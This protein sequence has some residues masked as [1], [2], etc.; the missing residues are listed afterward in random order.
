MSRPIRP[1]LDPHAVVQK[2]K[3]T[4]SSVG[5][6]SERLRAVHVRGRRQRE[7]VA[8]PLCARRRSDEPPAGV[9][10]LR[11]LT[12]YECGNIDSEGVGGRSI[13]GMLFRPR[14]NIHR[15]IYA[16]AG[17][18]NTSLPRGDGSVVW[19]SVT[20]C[21]WMCIIRISSLRVEGLTGVG[22]PGSRVEIGANKRRP[23]VAS[24]SH[25]PSVK[26]AVGVARPP[27]ANTRN[28]VV[29]PIALVVRDRVVE[30]PVVRT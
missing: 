16:A 7:E 20:I 23:T 12:E 21:S 15:W 14:W 11:R 18:R 29:A 5:T 10:C 3:R 22:V 17:A 13:H 19:I 25:L 4:E 8:L 1:T 26:V 30:A 24:K 27:L 6:D 28:A 2:I 9:H